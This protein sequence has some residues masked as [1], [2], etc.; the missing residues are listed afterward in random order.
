MTQRNIHGTYTMSF[1]NQAL[2][3][4][5]TGATNNELSAAWLSDINAHLDKAKNGNKPWALLNDCREWEWQPKMLGK[6]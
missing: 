1:E 3:S 6:V 2:Y 4:K 5:V